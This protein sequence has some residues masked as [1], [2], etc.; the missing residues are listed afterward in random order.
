MFLAV[1][2]KTGDFAGILRKKLEIK[3]GRVERHENSVHKEKGSPVD[4]PARFRRSAYKIE[5]N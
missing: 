4:R 5:L 2:H 3:R 1:E